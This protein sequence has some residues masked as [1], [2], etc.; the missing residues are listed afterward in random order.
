[1]LSSFVNTKY[2]TD[3]D[4]TIGDYIRTDDSVD[5]SGKLD[6]STY[7]T[8][9]FSQLMSD[10]VDRG[11]EVRLLC[12]KLALDTSV[13]KTAAYTGTKSE[14]DYA[15]RFRLVVDVTSVTGAAS[16]TLQGTNDSSAE[17]WT[18][19]ISLSV[20]NG[21][22]GNS[23]SLFTDSYKYYRLNLDS[24]GTS[25]TY[26]AYLIE[27]HY[28]K[29]HAYYTLYLLFNRLRNMRS[30]DVFADKSSEYLNMYHQKVDSMRMYYDINDSG[31]ITS[32]EEFI[33]DIR[34]GR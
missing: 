23:T 22:T 10:I 34:I 17:T 4:P 28:E 12:K 20:A 27:D 24:I 30:D 3:L 5:G 14:I 15:Q 29:P 11:K 18:N 13:T 31:S 2:L 9:A 8:K 19:I 32:D 6:A 25:I 33:S 7:I 1:M 21:A 26:T 16:F